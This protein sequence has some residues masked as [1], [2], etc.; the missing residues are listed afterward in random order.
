MVTRARRILIATLLSILTL[1]PLPSAS[2]APLAPGFESVTLA[3]IT[4]NDFAAYMGDD[5][6]VMRLF[7]ENNVSWPDQINAMSTQDV[8]PQIGET[9]IYVLAMGGDNYTGIAGGPGTGGQEDWAGTI[10]RKSLFTYPG[11]QV[12]VGR[13]TTDA[14]DIKLDGYLLFNNYLPNWGS[15]AGDRAG[16]TYTSNTAALQTGLSNVIWGPA[17]L[18]NHPDIADPRTS[19]TVSCSVSGNGFINKGWDF[20]DGSAVVFRFPLSAA[21]LPVSASNGQVVVDWTAPSGG[22]T[23][24]DYLVEYKESSESDTAYKSFSVVLHPSTVETVTGLTNGTPYTFRVA[25]RNANGVGTYSVSRSVTPVG[26]PTRPLNLS[27]TALNNAVQ[28]KFTV[29]ENSGGFAISNYEY[30]TNNGSTWTA[31]SPPSTS[32]SLTISGLTNSTSYNIKLRAV[33]PF[34]SGAPSTTLSA[35]PGVTVYRSVG[36]SS[37]T[38]D[39]VSGMPSG[40]TYTEGQSF[41]VAAAPTRSNFTFISWS[42]G[43]Q[44]YNPGANHTVG[45]GNVN[46]TAQWRQTSLAGTTNSD[47]ARVLTWNI[48]GSE[49]V[50]ATVSSDSGNSSVRVVIP[51]NSFDAGTEVIFWRLVN[52]NVAKTAINSSYDYLVNFAISWSIGDDV[53]TAKRVLTAR[54]PIQVTITNA[55]IQKNATA[56]MI[57]GGTARKLGTATSDG[58]IQVSLTEDPIITLANV[59]VPDAAPADKGK[60]E[61]EIRAARE[62]AIADARAAILAT[63]RE[64]KKVSRQQFLSAEVFGTTDQNLDLINIDISQ[65]A[66]AAKEDF[67]QVAKVVR[68]YATI[69]KVA[70]HGIFY[71]AELAEFGLV[72]ADSK[73]KTT[74]INGLRRLPSTALDTYA[75]IQ[76]S[77]LTIQDEINKRKARF[78]AILERIRARLGR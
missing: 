11:A 60:S 77:V 69:D 58:V 29:P 24:V 25:G 48:A 54:N 66:K 10:N 35:T 31:L 23:P 63:I 59:F 2:A 32:D 5:R 26:P 53:S 74:I 49:A 73:N 39:S 36:Y 28:V 18:D 64:N 78:T 43:T 14:R 16:G 72:P 34:G 7:W 8:V 57:L 13:A 27:Y 68:K 44:S 33:T 4:D 21:Q 17:T 3:L 65:L 61:A 50:D 62:K 42:D 75:K 45:A 47:I 15:T 51:S 12:A 67:D 71:Y 20:P 55:S 38:L 41:T 70:S 22:E 37:G 1:V 56:W 30:S 19:C 76:N 40:G 6:N 9:Y 46:L 52:Q